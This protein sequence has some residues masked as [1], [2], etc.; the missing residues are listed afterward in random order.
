MATQSLTSLAKPQN[1]RFIP[2]LKLIYQL[3]IYCIFSTN[4]LLEG[5]DFVVN[6]LPIIISP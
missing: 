5:K 4:I 6:W 2:L 3:Y 1:V